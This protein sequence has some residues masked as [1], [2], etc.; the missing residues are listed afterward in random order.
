MQ[1]WIEFHNAH[2]KKSEAEHQA[3]RQE[4]ERKADRRRTPMTERLKRVI[5]DIPPEEWDQ[6]RSID[7][8]VRRLAP[9]WNGSRAAPREVADGLR[10]LGWIRARAWRSEIGGFRSWWFPPSATVLKSRGAPF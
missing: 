9:K 5:R 7:Y 1:T 6:P 8:F 2:L 4:Q 10:E 3:K